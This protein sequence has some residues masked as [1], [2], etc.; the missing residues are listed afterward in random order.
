[1]VA[2]REA[3]GRNSG[4]RQ[5]LAGPDDV[6][7]IGMSAEAVQHG[8]TADSAR[9]RKVQRPLE[10]ATGNDERDAL[11]AHSA[12]AGFAG[13]SGIASSSKTF[14]RSSIGVRELM[15][16]STFFRPLILP[17]RIAPTSLSP[18]KKSRL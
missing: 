8:D 13:T 2:I 5:R 18:R 9:L 10:L 15:S 12:A 16:S 11:Q 14:W 6:R 7:L 17:I 4:V 1:M 3:E